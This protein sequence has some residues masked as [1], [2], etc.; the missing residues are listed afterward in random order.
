MGFRSLAKFNV[1]LLAKQGW[2]F[3]NNPTSLAARVYKAKYFPNTTFI[4]SSLGNNSS[5]T[6]KSIWAARGVLKEGLCWKVGNGSEIFVFN[7]AWV[8]DLQHSRLSFHVNS[9]NDFRVADLI[10]HSS[11]KWRREVLEATFSEFIVEKI[12]RIPLATEANDDVV[13]WCGEHSGEFSVRSAYKLLQS[14]EVDPTA[15]V[16]QNAYKNFYKKLWSLNL[17]SKIKITTW[18]ISWNYLPTRVNMHHRRLSTILLCPRCGAGAEDINHLFRECPV[19]LEIWKQLDL[20]EVL[21]NSDMMFKEWLAWAFEECSFRQ[22]RLFCC[23]L[24]AIWDER[25]RGVHERVWRSVEETVKFIRNYILELDAVENVTLMKKA[26]VELKKW[27]PP[28]EQFVK[29]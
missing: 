2:R 22:C 14:H 7:D 4:E 19:S 27:K 1:A 28:S 21:K 11:R 8:P 12:L 17:P 29:I 18:K 5:F 15:Y 9:L 24:W 6:W 3:M 13:A 10:D 26:Q 23:S 20:L 25:N 16:L